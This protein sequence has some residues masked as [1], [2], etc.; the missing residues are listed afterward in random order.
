MEMYRGW[1]TIEDKSA[2]W[3][4]TDGHFSLQMQR[5]G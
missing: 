5:S 2:K 1:L 4:E 3:K